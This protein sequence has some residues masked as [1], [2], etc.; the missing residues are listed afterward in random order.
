MS[1]T[2]E[3]FGSTSLI[4]VGNNYF[5]QPNG[6]VAVELS[7]GGTPVVAGQFGQWAPIG[8]EQT[9]T[10]YE[11]VWKM[12]GADEYQAWN[13][14]SSGNGVSVALGVVS[15]TDPALEALEITFHQDLNGDGT[16]GPVDAPPSPPPPTGAT[17]TVIEAFG[18][19]SLLQ[20]G[21][22]YFM[23]PNSGTAVELSLNGAAVTTGQFGQW[24]PIGAEQTATGYEV[25][26]KMTGA[27]Q[28]QAWNTDSSGNGISS[29]LGVVSGTDPALETLETTFH[30]DLNGDGTIG[31]VAAPPPPSQGSSAHFVYE[32][33]DANG[34]K[35]YDIMWDT[36]GSQAFA[37]RV[38]APT[39]PSN[40]HSHTFLYAL[41]VEPGLDQST[42]GSGLNELQKLDVQDKYD[43]TIIEPIFPNF[44]WYADSATD[45][46]M[47]YETFMSTILPA[48]V[49]SAFDPSGTDKNLLIGFSKSG[50][51][52]LDLLLKHPAVFADAA[53]WDFPGDMVY[54]EYGGG[55][56]YGTYA[57]FLANYQLNGTFLDTWKAP[58]T[59]QDRIWMSSS[60]VFQ[61]QVSDFDTLLTAHGILHT[62][63]PATTDAHAWSGGWLSDAVAGLYGLVD[64][65]TGT[66]PPPPPTTTVIADNGS[67]SLLQVGNNY[68]M[69]PDGGTAVEL[70][71][72]GAP[73]TVGQFGQWAPIG[74]VQT[75]TGFEVAW[76]M[77][78]ADEYQA[79]NTDSHGNG[80][81]TALGV[82]S[83]TDPSLEALELTF[84]QDLNGDG[85]IGPVAAPPPPPTTTVIEDNGSTSLLQ[86]GNNYFMQPNG[87]TAVE[88]SLNGAPVTTGQ[89]GQ[90]APIGA[91]QTANGFEVVWKM[92]G[93]DQYQAWNTDSSGNGNSVALGVVS[94]TDSAL[95]ALEATFQQDL[96]G[97]GYIGLVLNGSSGGQT[98]TAGSSPTTL[99][100][101]PGDILNA[102]TGADTFVFKT[103]FG[104]NAV[105]NFT[106]GTDVLQF[107]QSMFASAAA[108]LGDAQQVGSDVV[109]TYDAQDVVTLHN[110]QLA[111]LHASD[112]HIV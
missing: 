10:G 45:P 106:P 64:G 32:G 11:V 72:N 4:Q 24:A 97:D 47:N 109:I 55:A 35:L 46:T 108:A 44:S 75:A 30:Q 74:A 87:G 8:V 18:S 33:L 62:L 40:S 111:N 96:N 13:T 93:A 50:Y 59:T 104:S 91:E 43:A 79:W 80:T 61:S 15:G 34:A 107:S 54:N 9:A 101:G 67:T 20:V 51:G 95:E 103:N 12:T 58:F 39:N 5:L 48:W 102:G 94:G 19:T 14:D 26:W 7:L 63:S 84:H 31:P 69:K 3:A 82:V 25:V 68:F 6:G 105:S 28:Y 60:D 27:D 66:A 52:A 76:K 1:T 38:L 98:L 37:V 100:G 73:V 2:I 22:N 83:G 81:S 56:N 42:Y 110:T 29:A 77:T 89:F 17:T 99:I 71:L 36:P 112:F 57:N 92:T 90:W 49:D 85:T 21:N 78:G 41:P 53:A 88:L 65:T 16:I 23:Q 70:S 86:V